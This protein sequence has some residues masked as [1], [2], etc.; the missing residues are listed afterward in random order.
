MPRKNIRL[1]P[2]GYKGGNCFSVT[3]A[4]YYR[5]HI[6]DQADC[7]AV[8]LTCLRDAAQRF[9]ARVYAYC[10][11]P[12][13]VH[14]LAQT[15]A[16]TDFSKF[17][18][19]FKQIAGIALRRVLGTPESVWQPR[20]YDH[21]LRSDE[22]VLAVAEYIF[23]NPVRAGLASRPGEYPYSGSFEW[24]Q[25]F[26]ATGRLPARMVTPEAEATGLHAGIGPPR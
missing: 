2:E 6:F 10:F 11:M 19:F 17:V 4:T 1:P 5:K 7:A 13:H 3:I 23:R 21:G 24:S 18:T 26:D 16:N 15:P 14:L 20:F 8:A 12:D 22:G 25:P 9:D